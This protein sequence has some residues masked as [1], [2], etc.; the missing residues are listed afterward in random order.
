MILPDI[1]NI[2]LSTDDNNER[3]NAPDTV[4]TR[5]KKRI[6]YENNINA[7]S[8]LP[9]VHHIYIQTWGCSHNSSDSEYMAGILSKYGFKVT[10]HGSCSIKDQGEIINHKSSQSKK[11]AA[12]EEKL[13]ADLWILNSCT[14]K[15][16]AED[17][18]R[19][20]INEARKYGKKVVVAGCVPQGQ[21][22]VPY[23]KGVSVIGVQQIDRVI[24][25]V[26]ETLK[27]NSVQFYSKKRE[28]GKM[29]GGAKLNLP[30]IRKNPFIEI[31]PINT[32]CLNACTY[33]KTKHARGELGS[34][35]VWEII[36]RVDQAFDEGCVEIWLTSEDLGAYGRDIGTD[37]PT[38]LE[39][40][41]QHI[42]TGCMLRL[43]MTNPPYILEHLD[44]IAVILKHPR[45]YSFLHVPVQSGS[46]NVLGEMRREYTRDDFCQ[47][48]D[49]L[50]REIG[51]H[52]VTVATDIICGF[53]T[54]TEE[55]FN[56]TFSLVDKYRFSVLF[57]NQ[58]YP[59]PG[60]PAARM[61][62][63]ASP[64]EVKKRTKRLH[65]L[66]HSYE[67]YGDRIGH[68]VNVLVTEESADGQ[69][70]VGHTKAYE[71]VLVPREQR[72]VM[73]T[74]ARVTVVGASKHSMRAE[75]VVD[76]HVADV[77][78]LGVLP[79]SMTART[80]ATVMANPV[81]VQRSPRRRIGEFL[82]A[83]VASRILAVVFLSCVVFRIY[84]L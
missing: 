82:S 77:S 38:L 4:V 9:G 29:L 30:K 58:F 45:V 72:S 13:K 3:N 1:E 74:V 7:E 8:Y 42:P 48:V 23:L 15:T 14:V 69:F 51:R 28:G 73:G 37:L 60:T 41:V 71:Q 56:E 57:N 70:F 79:Q 39:E 5:I 27:G 24:E 12:D 75:F 16:P 2:V 40:M 32:G 17:H 33:C 11:V 63:V 22:K 61:D 6:P 25:V 83:A 34:Y 78:E 66:F 81:T 18:F 21:Q 10:L 46:D 19:N 49:T 31:L 52:H 80:M 44:R 65:E 84:L 64:V 26:E 20:M 76:A 36:D 59:R 43:G 62:R 55:D 67:P 35:P 68:Q 54:E 47:V 53:P 50:Y